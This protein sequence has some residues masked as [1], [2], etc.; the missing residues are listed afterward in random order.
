MAD[1][2][3]KLSKLRRLMRDEQARNATTANPHWAEY[4]RLHRLLADASWVCCTD[5]ETTRRS[6]T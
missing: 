1:D 2:L 3:T 6:T 4:Q 5:L